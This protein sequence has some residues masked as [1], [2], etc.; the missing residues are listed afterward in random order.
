LTLKLTFPFLTF[1]VLPTNC[2]QFVF[3]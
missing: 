2:L 3:S 1:M